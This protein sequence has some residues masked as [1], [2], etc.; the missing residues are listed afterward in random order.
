MSDV[1][2]KQEV[3]FVLA[4]I[5]SSYPAK[6]ELSLRTLKGEKVELE[7]TMEQVDSNVKVFKA[8]MQSND[9]NKKE[10]VGSIN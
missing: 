3:N 5:I 7:V 8:F 4:G 2:K 9:T 1:E 6:K 10:S